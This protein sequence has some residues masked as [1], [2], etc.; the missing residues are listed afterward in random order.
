MQYEW[1]K[2]IKWIPGY[3]GTYA[4][5][6]DG[7]AASYTCHP[8]AGG[9]P[10]WLTQR[11]RGGRCGR[12]YLAVTLCIGDKKKS[13]PVH[14]LVLEAFDKP[15]PSDMLA[16]HKDDNPANNHLDNLY[17]GTTKQ[18]IQDAKRNGR[19]PQCKLSEQDVWHIHELRPG[20][21]PSSYRRLSWNSPGDGS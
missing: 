21:Y 12:K 1:D 8:N 7:K 15:R 13:R 6:I 14:Q 2:T 10:V 17:W 19:I 18:N 3:E 11:W 4:V 20:A 9:E 5:T 16:L